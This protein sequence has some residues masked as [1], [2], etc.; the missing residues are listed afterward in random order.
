M[1]GLSDR[2]LDTLRRFFQ[3]YNGIQKVI[4]YGSRAKGNYRP[5]SDI[6]ITLCT[7]ACFSHEDLLHLLRDFDDSSM[8]YFVDVNIFEKLDSPSLKE[9]IQMVGKVLYSAKP[10]I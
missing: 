5:C 6:D 1:F 9:N 10:G 2:T 8:P 7:A 3:K 4:L